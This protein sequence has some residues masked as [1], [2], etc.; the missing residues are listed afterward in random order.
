MA[1]AA[2]KP[3]CV[4]ALREFR[5]VRNTASSVPPNAASVR[6]AP[7]QKDHGE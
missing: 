6:D 7:S 5:Q 2:G 1:H 4:A 3:L